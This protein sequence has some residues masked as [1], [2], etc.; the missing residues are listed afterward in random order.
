MGK[1]PSG[2]IFYHKRRVSGFAN[3][4]FMYYLYLMQKNLETLTTQKPVSRFL[5]LIA[6]L[7]ASISMA[8]PVKS[9]APPLPKSEVKATSAPI[10]LYS[11]LNL[12]G[13]GLGEEAFNLAVKGWEKLK[14]KGEVSKS[15]IAICDFTQSSKNKRLY[16]IDLASEKVLFNTLVAHGKNTGEEYAR[17]FSNKPSSYQSSLGFYATKGTYIGEHGLSLKLQGEEP[18][19]NDKAAERAIVL[20]GADYVSDRFVGQHGR[21]GRSFGCPSVPYNV[22]EQIINTIKDNSCLFV[23]YPDQKYLSASRVL[24]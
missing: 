14:A 10:A 19:F 3:V 16:V 17:F 2:N 1:G 6:L 5:I 13:I 12:A 20:H 21:L 7:A 4:P 22:H 8:W 18:G 11:K 23:Y 9:F 24:N 15:I